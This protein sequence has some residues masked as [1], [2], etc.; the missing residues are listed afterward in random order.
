MKF[1][2]FLNALFS[3]TFPFSS[4][5]FSFSFPFRHH[6]P[7]SLSKTSFSVYKIE[8]DRLRLQIL[9]SEDIRKSEGHHILA[10]RQIDHFH[11]D[12]VAEREVIPRRADLAIVPVCL[13]DRVCDLRGAPCQGVDRI[14]SAGRNA[15]PVLIA[16]P[17]SQRDPA[18]VG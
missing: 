3:F 10:C 11:V 1:S 6:F 9:V 8:Y 17:V 16:E 18:S 15:L 12:V 14:L 2:F 4:I 5:H 13:I 7:F